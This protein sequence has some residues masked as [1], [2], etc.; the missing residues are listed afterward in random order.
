MDEITVTD[1]EVSAITGIHLS[2]VT[3]WDHIYGDRRL[4]A[5]EANGGWNEQAVRAAKAA[6]IRRR[7]QSFRPAFGPHP[8]SPRGMELQAANV[9]ALAATAPRPEPLVLH[10]VTDDIYQL[11]PDH[12]VVR[13]DY[14][15]A[16]TWAVQRD[17]GDNPHTA[18]VLCYGRT[19]AD[20]AHFRSSRC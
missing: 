2:R 13:L 3:R 6:I 7:K 4:A 12:I 15:H 9:A 10:R 11:G 5:R 8:M 19:A 16:M 1:T 18:P 17:R 14:P 20:A